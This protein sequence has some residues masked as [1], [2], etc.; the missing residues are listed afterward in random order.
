MD[1][2][3]CLTKWTQKRVHSV[4]PRYPPHRQ[5][6]HDG[7][8]GQRTEK[9]QYRQIFDDAIGKLKAEQR[10]RVFAD[11]ERDSSRFPHAIWHK[12]DGAAHD[13]TIWCSNDC[14]L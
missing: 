3:K 14:L 6:P 12:P 11:I 1:T 2:R 8:P 10:Y 9:M 7:A 5:A 13:V 4:E